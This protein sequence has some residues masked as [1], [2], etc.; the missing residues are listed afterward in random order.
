MGREHGILQNGAVGK[1]IELLK[2]HA[3]LLAQA[4]GALFEIPVGRFVKAVAI[5]GNP[6]DGNA[7]GVGNLQKIHAAQKGA[8]AAPGRADDR[9]QISSSIFETY[10]LRTGSHRNFCKDP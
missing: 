5:D 9:N 3:D 2:H 7:A 6:R 1:E 8:L 4:M 10:P